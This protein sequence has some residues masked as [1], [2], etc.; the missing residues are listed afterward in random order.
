MLASGGTSDVFIELGLVLLIL[1]VVGR[2]ARRIGVPSIPLYLIAGLAMGEGGLIP[3]EASDDFIRIG[4]EVGVVLL[5]LLLGLEFSGEELSDG[6]RANWTSGL[7]DLLAGLL[8]GAIAGLLLGWGWSG[9]LVLGGVTYVSSSGIIAK[10]LGELDRIA[11]R[12]TSVVLSIL[13]MEDLAMALFLPVLG[14]V[15]AGTGIIDGGLAVALAFAVVGAALFVSIR[16]G[17]HMSRLVSSR[18][19]EVLLLTLLGLT[20]LVAGLAELVQ[21]SS[22]VGAFLIGVALSGRVADD[23]RELLEPLRDVFG[24][25][26]FVFFGLQIDPGSLPPVIIPALLIGVVTA[27]AKVGVG[28][29]SAQR[30]GIGLRGRWRAGL[31]LVPRG[32]FSIVIGGLGV[33]AGSHADLG[34]TVAAYVLIMAIG[35][36]LLMRYADALPLPLRR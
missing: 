19:K 20:L 23:G 21:V 30:A 3:L 29:W 13:V 2:A 31:S 18:S 35:G 34:P 26:F 15:L 17:R 1:A 10:L 12:E 5:L 16:F 22:A 24:G 4:A 11:N 27:A 32:E 8:P 9:A 36:S 33:A 6:L 28:W 14:V 25:L 7:V